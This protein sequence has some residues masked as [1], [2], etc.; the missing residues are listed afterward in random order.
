MKSAYF[1]LMLLVL[2]MCFGGGCVSNER[3]QV[4]YHYLDWEYYDGMGNPD[5]ATFLLDGR[6]MGQ[7]DKGY[8]DVKNKLAKYGGTTLVVLR[9]YSED[10][11]PG[12]KPKR[13][14]PFLYNDMKDFAKAHKIKIRWC[15]CEF[16]DRLES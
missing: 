15:Y 2:G 4:K 12:G 6:V 16:K 3:C 11:F 8:A 1:W 13:M 5:Q 10:P 14:M 9:A 7:G